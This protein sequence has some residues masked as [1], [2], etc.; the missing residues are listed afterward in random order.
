MANP[1]RNRQTA[2]HDIFLFENIEKSLFGRYG[3]NNPSYEGFKISSYAFVADQISRV[4]KLYTIN[5]SFSLGG[6]WFYGF[7]ISIATS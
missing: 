2:N 5:R 7:L 4:R 6:S 1:S 3:Y